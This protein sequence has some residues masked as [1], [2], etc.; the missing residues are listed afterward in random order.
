MA[1]RIV[2]ERDVAASGYPTQSLREQQHHQ[3]ADHEDRNGESE[4][5]DVG[6]HPIEDATAS[7][8]G[9]Q[10]AG[11]AEQYGKQG[12]HHDQFQ[13]AGQTA[14][15]IVGDR[16]TILERPAEITGQQVPEAVEVLGEHRAIEPELLVQFR[17]GG[18]IGGDAPLR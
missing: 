9:E 17:D 8:R 5:R 6:A 3:R 4:C 1:Q 16:T 18:G 15:Y 14:R 2:C 7:D 13:C 11:N 12:G 10:P